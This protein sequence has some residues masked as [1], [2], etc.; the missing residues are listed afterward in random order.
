MYTANVMS[1]VTDAGKHLFVTKP[2][3]II[4]FSVHKDKQKIGYLNTKHG[5]TQ[6]RS[7]ALASDG[8][9]NLRVEGLE[10]FCLKRETVIPSKIDLH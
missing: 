8:F 9:P 1:V 2:G 3:E 7:K 5:V 10:G 6:D 4:C